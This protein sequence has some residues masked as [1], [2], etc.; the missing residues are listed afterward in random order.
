MSLERDTKN[1]YAIIQG[2]LMTKGDKNALE[3][4][5]GKGKRKC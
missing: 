2:E 4:D 1:Y 5:Y 3:L